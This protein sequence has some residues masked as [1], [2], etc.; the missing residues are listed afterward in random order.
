MRLLDKKTVGFVASSRKGSMAFKWLIPSLERL[1]AT[2]W[3]QWMGLEKLISAN[4]VV[5]DL[6]ALPA[7]RMAEIQIHFGRVVTA[8]CM[9][10]FLNNRRSEDCLCYDLAGPEM[11]SILLE[12]LSR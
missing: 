3:Q 5:V 11:L 4:L 1:G 2:T 8:D 9:D 12:E 10:C 6:C 7:R